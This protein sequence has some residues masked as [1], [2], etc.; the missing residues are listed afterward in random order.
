MQTRTT[1]RTEKYADAARQVG[2]ELGI[3]VLDMWKIISTKAGWQPGMHPLPGSRSLPQN[4]VLDELLR[5][6]L[7]LSP[8]GN[9]VLYDG[10]LELI[11]QLWP[12]QMPQKLPLVLPEWSNEEGWATFDADT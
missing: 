7:H 12:D 2:K 5:D 6:G 11:E 1:G 4:A 3:A 9:Q 8:A 10:L